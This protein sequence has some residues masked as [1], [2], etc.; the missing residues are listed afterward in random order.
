MPGLDSCT[1]RRLCRPRSVMKQG[2]H[3]HLTAA[4][5]GESN[6]TIDPQA[7][8]LARTVLFGQQFDIACGPGES[9][10]EDSR[11][12]F[13]LESMAVGCW[14]GS[15]TRPMRIEDILTFTDSPTVMIYPCLPVGS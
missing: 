6:D 11:V 10:R 5:S 13:D 12:R 4:V 9:A 2:V 15:T 7:S 3:H 14:T 8:A 1:S